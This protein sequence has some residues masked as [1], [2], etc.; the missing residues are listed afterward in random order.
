MEIR[1]LYLKHYGKFDNH[2]IT[3]KPGINIIYGGNEAGKSTIHSFIRAMFFGLSRSRGKAAK[4]D[5]YQ[6]RQPWDTPG[7]F[8]GSMKVLDEG[9]IYRI[10]RCFDRSTQPLQVTCETTAREPEQPEYVLERLLGGISESAFVNTVF[11]PQ[12]RCET[13]AA[14]ARELRRYMVN[15]DSAMDGELDVSQALQSLRKKKKALEQQKKSEDDQ[16]EAAIGKKQIRAE[17]IRADLE[18]LRRQAESG[19]AGLRRSAA[20]GAGSGRAYQ[21]GAEG[22]GSGRAY[23]SGASGAAAGNMRRP[24]EAGETSGRRSRYGDQPEAGGGSVGKSSGRGKWILEILLVLAGL[25]A[26]AGAAFFDEWKVK[27]FLGVFG[28]VFLLMLLPVHFLIV[29]DGLDEEAAEAD[30]E[31][32]QPDEAAGE[33]AWLRAQIRD[34]EEE[35]RR[36]QDELE[37]LYGS[38]VGLECTDTEIAAVT[39]AI[40][41]ICELS[42]GIYAKS[43]GALNERA[44]E[45]LGEL[46][47]G[48]YTRVHLDET[49]EVRI[50]TPSRVLGLHQ[51][52]GGTMQQIYFS[53]RMAAG[54]ILSQ[55]KVL[56]VILDE[57]FA[58]YDDTRLEAAL[59]WLR[60]SG[61]QVILFTCQK[62]EREILRLIDA[63]QPAGSV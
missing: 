9:K 54:E 2:R 47:G 21:S 52:S 35:Y 15:S 34:K 36:L 19:R 30:D 46:T 49:M 62:R 56:P 13:E 10:D 18:T 32:E 41:R 26:L 63:Q 42:S 7:A 28:I 6:I 4:T 37:A 1:E 51:V 48:A 60:K 14:L 39:M 3:L 59:R 44:S 20:E 31:P 17:A 27:V 11:I 12:A 8:L 22:A 38:H 53:L 45:I 16:V 24:P 33:A 43:G 61:R 5:E 29:N 25:L 50:H 55:G 40:D 57:T 58:M 23:Q